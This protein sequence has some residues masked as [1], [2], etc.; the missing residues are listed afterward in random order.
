MQIKF[1]ILGNQDDQNGNPIPYERTTQKSLW[2]PR[3]RRYF[4]WLNYVR[5]NYWAVAQYQGIPMILSDAAKPKLRPGGAS[6]PIQT[7]RKCR[8]DIFITFKN[9]ARGDNDNVWKGIAD[10]LFE[11][12]RYVAGSFDYEVIDHC[13]P[14]VEVVIIIPE[15]N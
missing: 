11:N 5:A 1:T 12:D 14:K 15:E 13:Q 8:M 4:A 9:N 3:D 7:K 6:K 2:M 10:A